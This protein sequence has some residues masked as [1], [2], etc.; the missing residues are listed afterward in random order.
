MDEEK[1]IPMVGEIGAAVVAL[2][3]KGAVIN[4]DNIATYLEVRRKTVG[5]VI[6]KGVLRDAAKLVR[7][8]KL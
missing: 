6:H 5:N 7:E 3:A 1:A 4:R 2:I 8:G